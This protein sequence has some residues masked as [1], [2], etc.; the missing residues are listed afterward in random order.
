MKDTKE[1]NEHILE[2]ATEDFVSFLE[3]SENKRMLL[4]AFIETYQQTENDNIEMQCAK[5]MDEKRVNEE[6]KEGPYHKPGNIADL[7]GSTL[8]MAQT[9]RTISRS[10]EVT[11]RSIERTIDDRVDEINRVLSGIGGYSSQLKSCFARSTVV[12]VEQDDPENTYRKRIVFSVHLPNYELKTADIEGELE[13]G[14]TGKQV[15]WDDAVNGLAKIVETSGLKAKYCKNDKNYGQ[16]T[17]KQDL[18]NTSY[19][20]DEYFSI[21]LDF[22]TEDKIVET[23]R[24]YNKVIATYEN[25]LRRMEKK[26]DRW[27]N[28]ATTTKY[29]KLKKEYTELVNEKNFFVASVPDPSQFGEGLLL[30]IDVT[31]MKD[32][33][34]VG[35]KMQSIMTKFILHLSTIAASEAEFDPDLEYAMWKSDKNGQSKQIPEEGEQ[36]KDIETGK[37]YLV[38]AEALEPYE[39]QKTKTKKAA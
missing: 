9:E 33:H 21:I 37:V 7:L 2:E 39:E 22:M 23:A 28:K 36:V 35:D 20:P 19:T 15:N 8:N 11:K 3:N 31:T 29:L 1:K 12:Y 38:D 17:M 18:R 5:V 25:R 27:E 6:H 10:I 26:L 30:Y 24:A 14:R 16:Y 34:I 13:D 32:Y 4:D